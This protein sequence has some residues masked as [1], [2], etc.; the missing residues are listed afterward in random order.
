M[1]RLFTALAVPADIA[2]S[3]VT[4]RGGLMGARWIEAQDM[5]ITLRFIGDVLPHDARM[6]DDELR[7]I[8]RSC[9]TINIDDVS[10]FGSARPHALIARVHLSPALADMQAEQERIMRRLGFAPE[11]RKYTPHVTLA[12]LKGTTAD[13]LAFYLAQCGLFAKRSFVA[14]RL[15]LMSSRQSLGAALIGLRRNIHFIHPP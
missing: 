15:L 10:V 8:L 12:R 4:M 1:P 9:L 5:R 2:A 7:F 11:L 6:I 13:E 14:S 3:L